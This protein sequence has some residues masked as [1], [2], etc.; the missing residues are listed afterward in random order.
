MVNFI[1]GLVLGFLVATY[2]VS[3]VANAVDRGI[4]TAK[5]VKIT[6]GK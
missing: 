1:V 2:G 6:A 5:N 3:G 4:E